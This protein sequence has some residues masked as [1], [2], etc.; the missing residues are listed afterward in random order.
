LFSFFSDDFISSNVDSSHCYA[1]RCSTHSPED[2]RRPTVYS[3]RICSNSVSSSS[4]RIHFHIKL[5][6]AEY[7]SSLSEQVRLT[8]LLVQYR[9]WLW[10]PVYKAR[11]LDCKIT[12]FPNYTDKFRSKR[13]RIQV[14]WAQI[15]LLLQVLLVKEDIKEN[16]F[17]LSLID[18]SSSTLLRRW[19]IVFC[20]TWTPAF[21]PFVPTMFASEVVIIFNICNSFLFTGITSR[22]FGM[23]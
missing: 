7:T 12:A 17:R 9:T 1:K 6:Y 5:C 3:Y 11:F 10:H 23:R 21:S 19:F 2:D 8:T 16:L 4:R 18:Y 20:H 14:H 13:E 15:R 22:T